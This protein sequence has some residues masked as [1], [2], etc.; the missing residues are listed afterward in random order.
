M[1][2]LSFC[3]LCDVAQNIQARKRGLAVGSRSVIIAHGTLASPTDSALDC[4]LEIRIVQSPDS[5]E[6]RPRSFGEIRAAGRAA[7]SIGLSSCEWSR[8]SPKKTISHQRE[9]IRYPSGVEVYRGASFRSLNRLNG[10]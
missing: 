7:T 8:T 3:R 10:T 6:S 4:A 2:F 1:I 9:F 5:P